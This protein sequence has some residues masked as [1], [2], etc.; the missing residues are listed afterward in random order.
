MANQG[1]MTNLGKIKQTQ[2]GYHAAIK[3]HCD[4]EQYKLL[5]PSRVNEEHARDDLR[6]IRTS[7]EATSTRREGLSAMRATA[8]RLRAEARNT[9]MSQPRELKGYIQEGPAYSYRA[10]IQYKEGTSTVD[11]RG[12]PRTGQRRAEADLTKLRAASQGHETWSRQLR[13]VQA[14]VERLIIEA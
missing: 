6:R 12:P 1:L 4:G 5:G 7:S 11:I 9:Q 8:E 14:E 2:R 10:R 3:T 13:A